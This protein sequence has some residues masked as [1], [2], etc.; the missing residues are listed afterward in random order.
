MGSDLVHLYTRT[1]I[2][3]TQS[4]KAA[5]Q[6]R[7]TMNRTQPLEGHLFSGLEK[8]A[9]K[10]FSVASWEKKRKMTI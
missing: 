3:N 6:R 4:S 8:L 2:Q 1:D 7:Y 9:L 5:K 10:L